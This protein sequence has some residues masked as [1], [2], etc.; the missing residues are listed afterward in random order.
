MLTC[1]LFLNICED[2]HMHETK[3]MKSRLWAL[4]RTDMMLHD[5]GDIEL[6]SFPLLSKSDPFKIPLLL[7]FSQLRKFENWTYFIVKF[8][9]VPL[10]FWQRDLVYLWKNNVRFSL[11]RI[12]SI[13]VMF[14]DI[15]LSV[16][17]KSDDNIIT[18][19]TIQQQWKRWKWKS[20]IFLLARIKTKDETAIWW[21]VTF[22]KLR[23]PPNFP[24]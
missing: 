13:I 4:N 1:L 3:S 16:W 22:W 9:A 24:R 23:F 6:E 5:N 8:G 10:F 19:P 7:K 12:W 21:V 20:F 2:V 11:V 15:Y 17:R 14:M 18:L